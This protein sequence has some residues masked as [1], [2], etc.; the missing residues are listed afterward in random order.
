MR[1]RTESLPVSYDGSQGSLQGQLFNAI[2]GNWIYDHRGF[3][4]KR[5]LFRLVT[6][7]AVELEL[8]KYEASLR[9]RLQIWKPPVDIEAEARRIC[10]DVEQDRSA[11]DT[12]GDQY[13]RQPGEKS[14]RKIFAILLLIERPAK[15]RSFVEKGVCDADLP[16]I[17]VPRTNRLPGSF[18]L[19]RKTAV[20]LPLGCFKKWKDSTVARFEQWQ[21]AVL[22]PFFARGT[23]KHAPHYSL[24]PQVILPFTSWEK[25]ARRGGFGQVYKVE[26]HP[27]HHAFNNA[28]ASL[29]PCY[30]SRHMLTECQNPQNSN[31]VFAV[32]ELF[33]E[34]EA[35]FVR[36]VEILKRLSSD[37]HTHAYLISLLATYRQNGKYH[38][39]FPWAE[40]DLL[41]YWKDLNPEPSH[42]RETGMWLA[43]QCQGLADGLSTIHRYQTYSGNSLLHPNSF[44]KGDSKKI[45]TAIQLGSSSRTKAVRVL[46]GRHGDIKPNNILWFPSPR[47]KDGK[48]VLKISDFGI[49]HFSTQNSESARGRGL[50]ANSPTYRPPECD[51]G[52]G[53]IST[54]YDI[55]ALGCVYLEFITWYFGGSR[56]LEDF[57]FRRLAVDD[58]WVG[59]PTDTFFTIEKDKESEAPRPTVKESVTK[60][61]PPSCI[62]VHI[63]HQ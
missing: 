56:Y 18:K 37:S 15:I 44:P 41:G 60:V 62:S 35:D 32:K 49:A 51:L 55:W 50:V 45:E 13:M 42:D 31:E 9:K 59:F 26:I 54:S 6:Q 39:I 3:L 53:V 11:S 33:S 5:Q 21:W 61:N 48:G 34:K 29:P 36:E 58:A 17:K 63:I 20:D 52:D 25:V 24:Q 19:R 1:A 47:G 57:G 23:R 46:F 4:P 2:K 43:K 8:S 30:S 38:L 16:L 10:G 22:A 12:E 7:K 27:D 40:A 14:Y 28:E